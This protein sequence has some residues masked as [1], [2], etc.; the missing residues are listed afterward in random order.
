MKSINKCQSSDLLNLKTNLLSPEC[1]RN[2]Y[3]LYNMLVQ[4]YHISY[5]C[6]HKFY[7]VS[8]Y[9]LV[10]STI[11]SPKTLPQCPKNKEFELLH[12]DYLCGKFLSDCFGK[13]RN[14]THAICF[15][16]LVKKVE[17]IM[18]GSAL[19]LMENVLYKNKTV[20]FLR[21][22][23]YPYASAV[24]SNLIGVTDFVTAADVQNFY[25][26]QLKGLQKEP[27]IKRRMYNKKIP[28]RVL[29]NCLFDAVL[30]RNGNTRTRSLINNLIR[31]QEAGTWRLSDDQLCDAVY[32]IVRSGFQLI[33]HG[34]TRA[35]LIFSQQ[36]YTLDNLRSDPDLI[37]K[38]VTELLRFDPANTGLFRVTTS[39]LNIGQVNIPENAVVLLNIAAANRDPEYFSRPHLFDLYRPNND[40][41]LTF[42]G[43]DIHR[44]CEEIL[45]PIALKIALEHLVPSIKR[46]IVNDSNLHWIQSFL[47]RGVTALPL[48]IE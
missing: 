12:Y 25:L 35:I 10:K 8:S 31:A 32:M 36:P 1:T 38:F 45:V 3:A 47:I 43:N 4:H 44:C 16:Q 26:E 46:V 18:I 5:F 28:K 37:P 7:V 11:Y 21:S 22:F 29:K 23:S 13:G 27:F 34:L 40:V 6:Q 2:P 20:D 17:P 42:T 14:F 24:A 19:R 9:D 30:N 15:S 41:H 33:T 48:R 39:E